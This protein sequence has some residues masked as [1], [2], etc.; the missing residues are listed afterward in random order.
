MGISSTSA[1]MLRLS[2]MASRSTFP[3]PLTRDRLTLS[4][5]LGHPS[6]GPF[7]FWGDLLQ[8]MDASHFTNK[9]HRL[10]DPAL[11]CYFNPFKGK[12]VIDRCLATDASSGLHTCTLA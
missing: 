9:L 5:R 11:T 7:L 4:A 6:G 10:V 12:F 8:R 1:R 3:T 2:R